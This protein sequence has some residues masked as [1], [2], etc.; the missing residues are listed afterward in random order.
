MNAVSQLSEQYNNVSLMLRLQG[1]YHWRDGGEKHTNDPQSIANLQ[2]A[3]KNR[4]Q[5]AY[6]RYV[7]SSNQNVRNIF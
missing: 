2:A 7:Q 5:I 6:Q 1:D 3:A 4:N